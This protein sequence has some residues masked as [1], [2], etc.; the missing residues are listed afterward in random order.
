MLLENQ[1]SMGLAVS[2]V[3]EANREQKV[4]RAKWAHKVRKEQNQENRVIRDVTDPPVSLVRAVLLV[5]TANLV[6][7]VQRVTRAVLVLKVH[8]ASLA[9]LVHLVKL[10]EK[11]LK[12]HLVFKVAQDHPVYQE[13]M[14]LQ[15]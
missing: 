9:P 10:V 6:S 5:K 8:Q 4:L 13:K 15:V 2:L 7:V 14:E 11:G 1:V 12:V 3:K